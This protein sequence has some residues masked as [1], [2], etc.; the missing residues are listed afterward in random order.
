VS[1]NITLT[2][3]ANGGSLSLADDWFR[4]NQPCLASVSIYICPT[5]NIAECGSNWVC[6]ATN[7][8]SGGEAEYYG[9]EGDGRRGP[10][11]CHN[12]GMHSGTTYYWTVDSPWTLPAFRVFTA[13]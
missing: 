9:G 6:L 8:V 2:A 3:P 11:T 5:P 12:G 7:V 10:F 13:H 1:C 4:W